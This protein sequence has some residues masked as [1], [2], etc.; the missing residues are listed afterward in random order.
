MEMTGRYCKT[1]LILT[2]PYAIH[3]VSLRNGEIINIMKAEGK[4]KS[5]CMS[6]FYRYVRMF[7]KK[8]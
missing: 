4:G 1:C 5:V 7:N 2:I 3:D 8:K 6:I